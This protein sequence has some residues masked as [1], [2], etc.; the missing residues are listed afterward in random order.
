MSEEEV[1]QQQ[2]G[3]GGDVEAYGGWE[4]TESSG[5][6]RRKKKKQ[7]DKE[8]ALQITSLLD[9][10]FIILCFLL[11]SYSTSPVNVTQSNKLQLPKSSATLDPKDALPLVVDK[12]GITVDGEPVLAMKDGKIPEDMVDGHIIGKL[13]ERLREKAEEKRKMAE[14]NSDLSFKGELIVVCDGD[15]PFA[16]LRDILITAGDAEYGQFR[17]AVVKAAS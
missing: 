13:V 9:A 5:G 6:S 14:M 16:I 12:A 8:M 4:N 3:V 7:A 1:Q 2:A 15:L 17:F 11:K 10:L